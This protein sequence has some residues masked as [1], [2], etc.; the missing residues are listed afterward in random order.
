[1][2]EMMMALMHAHQ[3]MKP[4]LIAQ[5]IPAPIPAIQNAAL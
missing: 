1:L 4:V 2:V 5:P 3:N